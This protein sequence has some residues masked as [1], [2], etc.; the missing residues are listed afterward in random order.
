[1]MV[2]GWHRRLIR[3]RA[4]RLMARLRL[5]LFGAFQVRTNGNAAKGISS[6][7]HRALLVYLA[8]E[9]DQPHRREAL[10]EMFWPGKPTGMARN[11]LKQAI[12]NLRKVLGDRESLAPALL[13]SRNEIQFN[14]EGPHQIDV[15]EFIDLVQDV[16]THK[17]G[18][19]PVCRQCESG[20]AR[21]ADLY[22]GHFLEEFE[23]ANC[24]MFGEWVGVKREVF[25]RQMSYAL[26]RLIRLL[27]A[28]AELSLAR[29]YARR[30]VTLA[31]WIE[32]NHRLLM[33][34]YAR[35]G[36]RSRALRRYQA[37]RRV[38]ADEFGVEPARE[39][40]LL[41]EEIKNEQRSSDSRN[42]AASI[43]DFADGS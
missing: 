34:L 38:L 27:D 28:R 42:P 30:L 10:A 4:I 19:Q 36:M 29:R 7:K 37:C 16:R 13:V 33:S 41:Y 9:A 2:F 5:S 14:T 8:V 15:K 25:R 39:T 31:P 26:R 3:V 12:A 40:T 20:L 35:S 11:S 6:D 23:P 1:M 32:G 18:L 21:A 43:A 22:R 17:H 24:Q